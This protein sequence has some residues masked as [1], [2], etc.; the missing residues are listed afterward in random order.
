VAQTLARYDEF[1]EWYEEWI[2][3][4]TP[5]IAAHDLVPAL[6]GQRVLDVACGQ[7][8]LSRYLAR[9]GADVT[10]VDIS[11]AMLDRARVTGPDDITYVRADVAEPPAWWDG[12]SFDG[13]TCE[14]ALMDIDDL[15]GTLS[16]VAMVLRPGGWFVASI[17]HPCLP[18]TEK[19]QS[20]WPPGEGYDR[21]GWWT[22]PEHSRDGA[23]IRVGASHRKLSTYLNALLDA[24]LEAERF[25]EPPAP[26]PTYLLWRCRRR[27]L[28]Q[29]RPDQN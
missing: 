9:Q 3:D 23:R 20:S 19:G 28:A 4:T 10:G 5:L 18:G 27:G 16:A 8:R 26:V 21:E 14:L 17:V 22:S 2:A 24:G 29:A 15:A 6:I 25:I 1:A 11:A 7:G 12:R 13:C